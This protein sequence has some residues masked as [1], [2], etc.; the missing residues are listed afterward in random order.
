MI[1]ESG[2][3]RAASRSDARTR[4]GRTD[5]RKSLTRNLRSTYRFRERRQ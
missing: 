1:T 4:A 2:P 5:R 3:V